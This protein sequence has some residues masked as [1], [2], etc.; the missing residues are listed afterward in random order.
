MN[1]AFD[2]IDI[3]TANLGRS[4]AFYRTLGIPIPEGLD[5]APHV[6]VILPGGM[7]LAWDPV[8]TV[9]SF[10][11]GFTLPSGEGRIGFA[12]SA[13]TPEEVD[14]AYAAIV[15]QYPASAGTPPWNAPWGQRYATVLDPDGNTIDLYASLN[16]ATG[17]ESS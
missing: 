4:L 13:T 8:S 11:P 3:V 9:K 17:S 6:E 5:D 1:L 2:F 10:S 7:K 15:E 14:D 16:D 12:C